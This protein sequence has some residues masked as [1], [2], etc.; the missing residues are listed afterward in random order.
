MG[1]LYS[2]LFDESLNKKMQQKQMDLHLRFWDEESHL[3]QSR[4]FTSEFIGHATSD[5][6]MEHFKSIFLDNRFLV[7]DLVQI[8]MD[9]PNVNWEI[10]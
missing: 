3:V 7:K 9:G 10:L 5:I 2:V 6:M 1:N 4:Y 8:G